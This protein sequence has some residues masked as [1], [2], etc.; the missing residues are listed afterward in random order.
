V[1]EQGFHILLNP[2]EFGVE[3]HSKAEQHQLYVL[4]KEIAMLSG[5]HHEN[6]V[7]FR[8]VAFDLK[9]PRQ[10]PKYIVTELADCNLSQ[11]L[12]GLGR[13]L[14]IGELSDLWKQLL[15]GLVYL[16]SQ[17]PPIL[18]R[19]LKPDNV[20]VFKRLS[21][22]VFKIGDVGLSKFESE[23]GPSGGMTSA[24]AEYYRAP[25]EKFV[26]KSDVYSLGLMISEI[27]CRN[28]LGRTENHDRTAL[29]V[30]AAE[31]LDLQQQRSLSS[32]LCRSCDKNVQTRLSASGV[33]TCLEQV[34]Q[35]DT[36]LP[37]GVRLA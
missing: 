31:F 37:E 22:I 17:S 10:L 16:H 36:T 28:V 27:V 9:S 5:L 32:T 21:G 30:E 18:H 1:N 4:R 23:V 29:L 8:G 35:L 34:A 19:D 24:G 11:W 7:G 12:D 26:P 13:K 15:R 3:P 6:L 25:E 20:L 14:T 33:L 2:E